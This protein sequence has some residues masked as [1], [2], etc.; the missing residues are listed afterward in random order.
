MTPLILHI[1]QPLISHAIALCK[2]YNRKIGIG[3]PIMFRIKSV[4]KMGKL[5]DTYSFTIDELIKILK[6]FSKF[7][8]EKI[9]PNFM[10]DGIKETNTCTFDFE[11]E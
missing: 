8:G 4:A 10:I 6:K 3:F 1:L 9:M 2:K 5:L 7:T 11:T